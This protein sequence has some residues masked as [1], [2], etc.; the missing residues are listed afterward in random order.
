M[1]QSTKTC[2]RVHTLWGLQAKVCQH[3]PLGHEEV[4]VVSVCLNLSLSLYPR[5]LSR[6]NKVTFKETYEVCAC[7]TMEVL[8]RAMFAGSL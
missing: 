4:T 3:K 7:D 8:A 5:S 2:L 1:G 6:I